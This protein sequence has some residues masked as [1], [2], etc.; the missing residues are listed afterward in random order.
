M[1]STGNI[2]KREK[3]HEMRDGRSER[4]INR[5]LERMS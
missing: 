5:I 1:N 4:W 2:M 3:G